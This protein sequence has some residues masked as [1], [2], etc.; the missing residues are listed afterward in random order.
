MVQICAVHLKYTEYQHF[1]IKTFV[2]SLQNIIARTSFGRISAL[3]PGWS[4]WSQS[5]VSFISVYVTM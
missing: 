3:T 2:L 1:S 4:L 5:Y